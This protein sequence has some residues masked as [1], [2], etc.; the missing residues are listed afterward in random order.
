[1]IA[2][3]DDPYLLKPFKV[4]ET[5]KALGLSGGVA[6]SSLLNFLNLLNWK[7]STLGDATVLLTHLNSL[8][9]QSLLLS[10]GTI[11]PLHTIKQHLHHHF[12]LPFIR[13]LFLLLHCLVQFSD[14]VDLTICFLFLSLLIIFKLSYFWSNV[15]ILFTQVLNFLFL[16]IYFFIFSC[17][18]LEIK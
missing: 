14:L 8:L 9:E 12:L 11:F 3:T 5:N 13:F 2:A 15:K 10:L 7:P 16:L 6:P 1:M 17:D 4:L 18:W